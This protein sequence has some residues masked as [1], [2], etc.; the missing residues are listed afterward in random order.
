MGSLFLSLI[1]FAIIGFITQGHYKTEEGYRKYHYLDILAPLF[2]MLATMT[3]I[4]SVT[5]YSFEARID[6]ESTLLGMI[7][8][9][10]DYYYFDLV[11]IKFGSI[12]IIM[13][14]LSLIPSIIIIYLKQRSSNYKYYI[15]LPIIPMII[16]FVVLIYMG[17]ESK[18][19]AANYDSFQISGIT[20]P[21]GFSMFIGFFFMIV[22]SVC[23]YDDDGFPQNLW[24]IR[25]FQW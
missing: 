20:I 16:Q 1:V 25:Q 8:V 10:S 7:F 13:L 4:C 22:C 3:A 24:I 5:D 14:F 12:A 19:L 18:E 11:D 2:V 6:S 9:T 23:E 15:F 17:I 21:I